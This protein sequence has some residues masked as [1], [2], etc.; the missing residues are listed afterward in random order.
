MN[1]NFRGS[2]LLCGAFV[3]GCAMAEAVEEIET[4]GE[5]VTPQL[6]EKQLRNA[7]AEFDEAKKMFNPWYTGPLLT[8][9]AH[10]LPPGDVNIQVYYFLTDNFATYN[11]HGKAEKIPHLI[12]NNPQ[13]FVLV[14]ITKWLDAYVVPQYLHNNQAGETAGH[15]ADLPV[16][17]GFELVTEKPYRPAL[18]FGIQETFPTGKYQKLDPKK[19]AVDSTG[20]G[21]YQTKLSLNS[22]KVVW[23]VTK[24]PMCIR[25]SLNYTIA[26]RVHVRGFNAYGG[27]FGTAGK[28]KPGNN[29]SADIG[30]EYSFTQRWVAALDVVYSYSGKTTFSGAPGFTAAGTPAA[31]GGLFNEQLSLAP[32]LEYNP[33]G[34]LGFIAGCW[35][36]VWG[37][38]S[39]DFVSG[40]AS[41]TYTF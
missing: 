29:F 13:A 36:T 11:E 38:N 41:V 22:S 7:Q 10:V 23:W 25:G 14:G 28:V 4:P 6:V 17:L 19:G 9:S 33:N 32:A 5:P 2:A 39:L 37:K 3:W 40:V 18:L 30:Y 21:S 34:N 15:F 35:F 1:L 16:G 8:P 24:H 20:G 27:G 31:V 26:G 12:Q